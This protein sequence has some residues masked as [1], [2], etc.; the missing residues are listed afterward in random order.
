[1]EGLR[2]K[3]TNS[4][5]EIEKIAAKVVE[6]K[7]NELN[8]VLGLYVKSAEEKIGNLSFQVESF[9]KKKEQMYFDDKSPITSE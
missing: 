7:Q 2:K 5:L 9:L 1:L 3:I 8:E 6:F 4:V